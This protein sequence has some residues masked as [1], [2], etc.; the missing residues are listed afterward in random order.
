LI[1]LRY[2][3]TTCKFF[4]H[5]NRLL[6]LFVR[7][8][9]NNYHF[10]IV[11]VLLI[12]SVIYKYHLLILQLSS[13]SNSASRMYFPHSRVRACMLVPVNMLGHLWNRISVC[14]IRVISLNTS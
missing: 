13:K 3:N 14:I 7:I 1:T 8:V 10:P 12:I 6:E 5:S 4:L 9:M 2:Q 11:I